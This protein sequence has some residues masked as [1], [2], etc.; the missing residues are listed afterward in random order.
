[1]KPTAF[2]HLIN[3][4]PWTFQQSHRHS[5]QMLSWTPP[6]T[7][8]PF[9][10]LRIPLTPRPELSHT[11]DDGAEVVYTIP[12]LSNTSASATWPSFELSYHGTRALTSPSVKVRFTNLATLGNANGTE[13][14]LPW[15]SGEN[16]QFLLAAPKDAAAADGVGRLVSSNPPVAWM[17]ATYDAISC[18]PLRALCLP[19]AHD[20]GMSSFSGGSGLATP[21]NTVTQTLDL[22]GQL[23]AG[24]RWFDLRPVIA[25]GAWR[26]GHYSFGL[27]TWHGGNG[28]RFDEMVGQINGFLS[29]EG[30]GELVVLRL[31]QGFNTD[32]FRGDKGNRL[33]Q[34]EWRKLLE[35]LVGIKDL[36]VGVGK[37]AD[38]TKV[39]LSRFIGGGRSGVIV[40]VD[41]KASDGQ[42]VVVDAAL[43]DKG[44]VTI[45]QFP[46][47]DS[48]ANT[49]ETD[50][51]VE[52]Q[53]TKMK[54]QRVDA[55][56]RMFLLSWTLT[57]LAGNIVDAAEEVN[58][59]LGEKL[60]P[61][62]QMGRGPNI[63][64]VDAFPAENREVAALCM[65][66]NYNFAEPC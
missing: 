61:V 19:G 62:L 39:P 46:L 7:I 14:A 13:L 29:G 58:R 23:R 45:D 20:A 48:Y 27:T 54:A 53:L 21:P 15:H 59:V 4:T 18:R 65:A 44:V 57:Q 34:V 66:I 32:T 30:R 25:G 56:S 6:C 41:S 64:A 38:M 40:V 22:A 24:A 51:M 60:W 63:I 1:M 8:P 16:L 11:A 2:L 26:A 49:R 5:Y 31:Q 37:E 47:Y 36:V 33:T 9:T 17:R 55:G 28:Q 12:A 43:R 42:R 50:T 3:A 35:V 10:S 52:N